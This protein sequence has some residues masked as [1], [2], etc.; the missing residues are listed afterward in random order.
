MQESSGSVESHEE[1][2]ALCTTGHFCTPRSAC[3]AH[4]P[5]TALQSRLAQHVRAGLRACGPPPAW[6]LGLEGSTVASVPWGPLPELHTDSTG[7]QPC[8]LLCSGQLQML[9]LILKLL[10]HTSS[11]TVIL[12][13]MFIYLNA[14]KM[15]GF[16]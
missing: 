9:S 7:C 4:A 3:P 8:I 11:C 13:Q 15:N 1:K 10:V 14:T 2:E 16:P 6:H 5:D 12:A